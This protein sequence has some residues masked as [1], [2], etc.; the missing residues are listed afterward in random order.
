MRPAW[1]DDVKHFFGVARAGGD[2]LGRACR[3]ALF[4]DTIIGSMLPTGG[5]SSI[6]YA[7]RIYQLPIGVIGIAAGTVLLPEMSRRLAAGDRGAAP[8]TRRTGPWRFRSRS[9]RRSS[10]PSS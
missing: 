6:Y 9:P 3:L 4:A 8:I 7:D 10:S 2:R 5:V 1:N